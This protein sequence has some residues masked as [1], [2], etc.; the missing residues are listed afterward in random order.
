MGFDIPGG[1]R[2]VLHSKHI[3]D[4]MVRL[5]SNSAMPSASLQ[6]ETWRRLGL[7]EIINRVLVKSM[8]TSVC[9]HLA[10]ND[11]SAPQQLP[12]AP[13]LLTPRRRSSWPRLQPVTPALGQA[14][15]LPSHCRARLLPSLV[16]GS[17][18]GTASPP[19]T[20]VRNS[21]HS[22]HVYIPLNTTVRPVRQLG[23]ASRAHV[24]WRALVL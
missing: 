19:A 15:N 1:Q 7:T 9:A 6:N 11:K 5:W 18:R 23:P 20:A 21:D 2:S 22:P 24:L 14:S 13:S 3:T 8:W 12:S 10:G 16:S 17:L 4:A